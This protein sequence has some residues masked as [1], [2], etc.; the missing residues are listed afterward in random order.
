MG[1]PGTGG[2]RRGRVDRY[3]LISSSSSSSYQDARQPKHKRR[4]LHVR[5]CS[6]GTR[7]L[8]MPH[9]MVFAGGLGGGSG[10]SSIT[11]LS[12]QGTSRIGAHT[13]SWI[14]CQVNSYVA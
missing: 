2:A 6:I 9:S 8:H 4:P 11:G 12:Y 14:L 7:R 10:C 5:V 1:G 3:F 13:E